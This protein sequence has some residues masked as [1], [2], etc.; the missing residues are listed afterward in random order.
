MLKS[1]GDAIHFINEAF[2][3]CKA[4]ATTC[5]GIELLKASYLAGI[6][7]AEEQSETRSDRGVVTSL[8]GGDGNGVDREF[9]NAIAQHRHWTREY[10]EL[11]P[12]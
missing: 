11:V 5:E 7:L 8:N 2:R 3:H 1:Q 12:A 4:I 6:E 9:I 10:K